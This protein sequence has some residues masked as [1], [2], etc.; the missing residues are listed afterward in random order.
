VGH[1]TKQTTR[2]SKPSLLRRYG[3]ATGVCGVMGQLQLNP[4]LSKIV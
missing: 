3:F 1:L 4:E 2:K